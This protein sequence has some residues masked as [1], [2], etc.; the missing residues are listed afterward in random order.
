MKEVETKVG[1]KGREKCVL[2][3]PE[4]SKKP[5]IDVLPDNTQVWTYAI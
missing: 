4:R 3:A 1:A 5:G 2:S